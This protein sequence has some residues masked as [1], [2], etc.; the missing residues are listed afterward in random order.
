M[1][2][3]YTARRKENDVEHGN[4]Q[5]GRHH[6]LDNSKARAEQCPATSVSAIV[7]SHLPHFTCVAV[8]TRTILASQQHF[9]ALLAFSACLR[10]TSMTFKGDRLQLS[11][12]KLKTAD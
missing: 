8:N 2:S 6:V 1:Q 12:A 11:I 9:S 7:K 5:D 4:S 3:S 10:R